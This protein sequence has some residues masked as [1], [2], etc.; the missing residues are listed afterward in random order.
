M[1]SQI[2]LLSPT[3]TDGGGFTG[4]Q[5][6]QTPVPKIEHDTDELGEDGPDTTTLPVM[7]T[8]ASLRRLAEKADR[9]LV[10]SNVE[11]A[12][13]DSSHGV[14]CNGCRVDPSPEALNPDVFSLTTKTG[15]RHQ[16][17]PRQSK[18]QKGK[19]EARLRLRL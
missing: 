1:T 18:E 16:M 19:G 12:L 13:D 4:T 7:L 10:I 8:D 14:G 9:P 3:S 5:G 17:S 2:E 6:D 11:V 15:H